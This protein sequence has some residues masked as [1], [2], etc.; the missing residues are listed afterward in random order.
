MI[1]TIPYQ[2]CVDLFET[3]KNNIT[4]TSLLFLD[5]C[6]NICMQFIILLAKYWKGI[7]K[8]DKVLVMA[9]VC[10]VKNASM[11]LIETQRRIQNL[12]KHLR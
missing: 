4:I 8:K 9:A 2:V 6:H 11:I 1:T 7:N 3:L 10:G 12:F 5:V